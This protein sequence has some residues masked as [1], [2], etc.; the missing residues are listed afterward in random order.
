MVSTWTRV[1]PFFF[2]KSP[3]PLKISRFFIGVSAQSAFKEPVE[4]P[5]MAIRFQRTPQIIAESVDASKYRNIYA[6]IFRAEQ[7]PLK[8]RNLPDG[9]SYAAWP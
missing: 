6:A 8:I 4:T 1:A 3:K 5:Y 7:C 9:S 2:A